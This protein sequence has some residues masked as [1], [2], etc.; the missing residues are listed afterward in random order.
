[1]RR[2]WGSRLRGSRRWRS[3]AGRGVSRRRRGGDFGTARLG[4]GF[5]R[6]RDGETRSERDGGADTRPLSEHERA[7]F[8][9]ERAS[10][11][12]RPRGPIGA[13]ENKGSGDRRSLRRCFTR[14]GSCPDRRPLP[15][16]TPPRSPSTPLPGSDKPSF[17]Y[18]NFPSP[19]L[20]PAPS[21]P[22]SR[23]TPGSAQLPAGP[24]GSSKDDGAS[25]TARELFC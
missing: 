3:V 17:D 9:R 20:A 7:G 10:L 16:N 25:D 24:T 11:H 23:R 8:E 1:M 15:S 5:V 12:V 2:R 14:R 6:E 18:A 13:G 22:S 4:R 19:L 21:P